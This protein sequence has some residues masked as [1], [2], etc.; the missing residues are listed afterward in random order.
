MSGI[1][2]LTPDAF[3]NSLL[4]RVSMRDVVIDSTANEPPPRR[5]SMEAAVKSALDFL[6]IRGRLVREPENSQREE[7]L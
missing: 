7:Q 4:M 6:V 1:D 2:A 5:A 3:G